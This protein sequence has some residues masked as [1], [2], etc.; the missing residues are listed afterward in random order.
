MV[1]GIN[2]GYYNPY[3]K[4]M[5]EQTYY[6]PISQQNQTLFGGVETTAHRD[7]TAD[8]KDDGS[9]GFGGALKNMAK[10]VLNFV[11]S[12]FTDESGNFSLGKTLKSVAIAG[13]FVLGNALTGGA[14]TP[15]LLAGGA[16]A[17]G[18][19]AVKAG[20]N[21]ATANT[22]AEAEA[23]W[24]SMG[25]SAATIAATVVGAKG[26]AKAQAS[27]AAE[28]EALASGATAEE[29][30]QAGAQAAARYNG[31]S[32]AKNAVGRTFVDAGSNIKAGLSKGW[33]YTSTQFGKVTQAYKDGV[34]KDKVVAKGESIVHDAKLYGRYAR[35]KAKGLYNDWKSLTPDQTKVVYAELKQTVK[36]A[37]KDHYGTTRKQ[38]LS[39]IGSDIK[40]TATNPRNIG[41]HTYLT[42]QTFAPDF[43]D[44]LS[45]EEQ[46]YFDSL[47]KE[48]REELEDLYYANV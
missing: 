16:L 20:Y 13:A 28:A 2:A 8:G 44:S 6:T 7:N 42:R 21:I 34:L 30:A 45:K 12:P 25:S 26:Y 24:Q 41:I 27:S 22:D 47:P 9:I 23:A 36:D 4:N 38:V 32:G 3:Q 40:A 5:L 19:G 48:Q 18:I 29:A 37:A 35:M 39:T 17:G 14:L 31:L 46:A 1:S 11:T 43:Y 15:I 10:G 33:N